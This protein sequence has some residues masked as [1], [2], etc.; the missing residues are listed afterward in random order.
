MVCVFSF[1]SF[2]RSQLK[3]KYSWP[4]FVSQKCQFPTTSQA[5]DLP[6][7]KDNDFVND[8]MKLA[9]GDEAKD[10]LMDTLTADVEVGRMHG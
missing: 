10:K 5:K 7:Y 8:G 9:I 3:K 1:L 2:Q 6:T 4:P